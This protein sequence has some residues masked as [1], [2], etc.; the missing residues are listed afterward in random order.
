MLAKKA[1]YSGL[2]ISFSTFG[3]HSGNVASSLHSIFSNCFDVISLERLAWEIL[4]TQYRK[5]TSN[6]KIT[7]V[8]LSCSIVYLRSPWRPLST[9][10][11]FIQQKQMCGGTPKSSCT[12]KIFCMCCFYIYWNTFSTQPYQNSRIVFFDAP[13]LWYMGT[14]TRHCDSVTFTSNVTSMVELH[15]RD[16][17]FIHNHKSTLFACALKP[18]LLN[19]SFTC[20]SDVRLFI[21]CTHDLKPVCIH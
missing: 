20:C 19:F 14:P 1:R 7:S 8:F 10:N 6:R 5:I 2:S 16:T 3:G 12:G 17:A 11:H 4:H 9:V 15:S 13:Y 21:A 18:W